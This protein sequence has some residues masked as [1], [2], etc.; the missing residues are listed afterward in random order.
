VFLS[1][2]CY[3]LMALASPTQ[4]RRNFLRKGEKLETRKPEEGAKRKRGGERKGKEREQCALLSS[5]FHA[6]GSRDVSRP[7]R[8]PPGEKGSL[9]LPPLLF[10]IE[11]GGVR[12]MPRH[13]AR[14][15]GGGKRKKREKSD[16]AT[17]ALPACLFPS[18]VLAYFGQWPP[19][20][21]RK[22]TWKWGKGKRGRKKG[23]WGPAASRKPSP[24]TFPPCK[25][26][27][28]IPTGKESRSLTRRPRGGRK[29]KKEKGKNAR[30]RRNPPRAQ[31]LPHPL[32]NS[33]SSCTGWGQTE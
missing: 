6:C 30:P 7:S 21:I 27:K 18:I 14:P 12:G 10:L 15:Q 19:E 28:P 33:P 5:L 8:C 11:E 4:T 13:Q 3:G 31:P 20:D 9:A 16:T 26:R 22:H 29:G 23:G 32:E 2:Q 24:I 17:Q 25:I 1:D